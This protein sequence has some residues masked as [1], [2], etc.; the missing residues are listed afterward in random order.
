MD[1]ETD[2]KA[3]L[4]VFSTELAHLII[5]VQ[6]NE[7]S[8][9]QVKFPFRFFTRIDITPND[10]PK[11]SSEELSLERTRESIRIRFFRLL[12]S[13]AFAAKRRNIK[14]IPLSIDGDL[15][16][17]FA[18]SFSKDL[19][20]SVAPV[21]Q[22]WTTRFASELCS[23]VERSGGTVTMDRVIFE[24]RDNSLYMLTS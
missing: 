3:P 9:D 20:F 17:H 16:P 18:K 10:A 14:E 13:I 8:S 6:K 1:D 11:S 2:S 5:E 12:S 15:E 24:L 23:W 22:S 7:N 4:I 21:N 19:G